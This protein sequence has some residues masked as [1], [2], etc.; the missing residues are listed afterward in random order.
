MRLSSY[1]KVYKQIECKYEKKWM[2][3]FM[4]SIVAVGFESITVDLIRSCRQLFIRI[5]V[6]V[7]QKFGMDF[8]L[9]YYLLYHFF[10]H[11]RTMFFHSY[12]LISFRTNQAFDF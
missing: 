4:C 5:T 12:C 1:K 10:D 6:V 7:L 9:L 8:L 2:R 11:L 3:D